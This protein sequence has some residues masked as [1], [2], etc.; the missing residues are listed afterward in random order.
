MKKK[1][2]KTVIKGGKG[3]AGKSE[4]VSAL[5]ARPTNTVN[6]SS[7]SHTY[8]HSPGTQTNT[9]EK[10]ATD[11][12]AVFLDTLVRSRQVGQRRYKVEKAK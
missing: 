9:G 2:L 12:D 10:Q 11:F 4:R 8:T 5:P 1:T 3:K 6:K 7:V